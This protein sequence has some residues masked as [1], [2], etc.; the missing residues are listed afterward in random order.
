MTSERDLQSKLNDIEAELNRQ[1]STDRDESVKTVFPEV[2]ISPTAQVQSWIDNSKA[3]FNRLPKV[4][5][6]A[7]GIGGVW[8]GFSIVGAVLHVVSSVISIAVL[9]VVLYFGYRLFTNSSDSE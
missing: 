4:G 3:L 2:D 1:V 5:K 6:I 8:L 7:V 9:G